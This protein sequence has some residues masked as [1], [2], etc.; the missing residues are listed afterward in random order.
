MRRTDVSGIKQSNVY[1]EP[2]VT[3]CKCA[4]VY[5]LRPVQPTSGV[6]LQFL[7]NVWCPEDCSVMKKNKNYFVQQKSALKFI[8]RPL[9][10]AKTKTL[11]TTDPCVLGKL[12]I[13]LQQSML[14]LVAKPTVC[15]VILK[16]RTD[17][18]WPVFP[19]EIM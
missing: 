12:L 8:M 6:S 4:N 9:L 3:G 19:R 17:S 1:L 7:N 5:R 16:S 18:F 13:E 10:G 11:G 14:T 2:L 15:W